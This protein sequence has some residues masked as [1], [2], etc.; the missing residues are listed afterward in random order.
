MIVTHCLITPTYSTLYCLKRV[1]AIDPPPSSTRILHDR[2]WAFRSTR[3]IS[4]VTGQPILT[5]L[6]GNNRVKK[7]ALT[8]SLD[9]L[10]NS[11][12]QHSQQIMLM[13]ALAQEQV[14]TQQTEKHERLLDSAHRRLLASLKMLHILQKVLPKVQVNIATNQIN[15]G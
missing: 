7:E 4:S 15:L 8:H 1:L 6:A 10:E 3:D 2:P 11:L 9:M 5:Q 14:I 13:L 12:Q